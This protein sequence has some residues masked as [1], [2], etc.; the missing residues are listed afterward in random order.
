MAKLTKT[1]RAAIPTKAFAL[2]GRRYPIEDKNHAR[3]ALTDVSR[4]GT[5]AQKAT[6]RRKVKAKF[7]AIGTS[8]TM[9]DAKT[10]R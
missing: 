6:I 10:K 2:P 7:S 8:A 3:A 9:A 1:T 4:V 5:P